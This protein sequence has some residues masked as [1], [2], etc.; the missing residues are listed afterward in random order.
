MLGV[1]ACLP[2][3]AELIHR[4]SFNNDAGDAAGGTL[5]DS[6]GGAHGVVQGAGAVFTGTGLDLPGGSSESAAYGDLPNN[7]ISPHTEVT[8]EG[9]IRIESNAGT[10]ARIFDFGSTEPGG[11]IAGEVTGP[12]NTN[13]GGTAGLDYFFL[14]AARGADYN[15]QRVEIRNEDPAGGGIGT[16]DSGVPTTFGEQIHY[17][18]TWKDTGPGTSEVNYWRN[19]VQLT[20]GAMV[21]FN[22]ADLN[23]VNSWLGRSNWLNDGNLDATF[24]EFRIYDEALSGEQITASQTIGPDSVVDFEDDPDGDMIPTAY[25][26][27]YDFLNP[28]DPTDASLDEEGDGLSNLEEF[29]RGTRPD[30]EDSD[31]DS[32]SD[33]DEVNVHLTNPLVVDTDLDGLTDGEEVNTE[34][35]NPLLED[36]D[37]D[38]IYDAPEVAG[39]LNPLSTDAT[40]PVL[41]HR[42]AFDEAAGPA[43][44]GS[45]VGDLIGAADGSIVGSG[46]MWTGS[47]LSLPGGDGAVSDAAYVDL[48]N[49]L[50][51]SLDHLTF[52]AWYTVRSVNNWGRLW[53]FGSTLGGEVTGGMTGATEG[54]DYFIFAPSRGTNLDTQRMTIRNLDPLAPGGG[55]TPTSGPEEALDTGLPSLIDQQYHVAGVWTSDGKG[56]GQL[57]IYRD[58]VR[59]GTRKTTITPRDINDVNNWLGRSNWTGDGYLHGDLNEFR[60]YDGAMNDAAAAESFA[61]GPDAAPGGEAPVITS[62]AYNKVDDEVTLTFK[63]RAGRTYDIYWSSDLL[64]FSNT[65]QEDVPSG[66]AETIFGPVPNP[67][68]GSPR[69]FFRVSE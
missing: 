62:I 68:P 18:V 4:Y 14:S 54:Q 28:N 3:N 1:S 9:W 20:T 67:S 59:E 51:S 15:V 29:Q 34:G 8:V 32:L 61:A 24:E 38:G 2:L 31:D 42:Y 43:D 13:G 27:L 60:I 36:S 19:G 11:G 10:W 30:D 53:D 33:G 50:M 64:D 48:P 49:G 57:I 39:G 46:G 17:A 5:E 58:G 66:G 12:G 56:G 45:V 40:S 69:I 7:L 52:E 6:I 37:S 44:A 63:S 21:N 47:A 23:D 41:L 22:L 16:F 35:T 55:T 65:V 26:D 25:E